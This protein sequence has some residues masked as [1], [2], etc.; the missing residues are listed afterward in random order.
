MNDVFFLFPF[1]SFGHEGHVVSF[2]NV[3]SI[4]Q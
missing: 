4:D 2:E 1:F 3:W